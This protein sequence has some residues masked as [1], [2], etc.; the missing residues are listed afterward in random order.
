MKN[1]IIDFIKGF[2]LGLDS[3]I[4]GFSMGT[5]AIILKIY[6]RMIED[7]SDAP[8]HPIKFLKKD[9]FMIVGLLMGLVVNIIAI[10]YL[11][12][13]FPLQAVCF[14][15][16]L[17]LCGIPQTFNDVKSRGI[18]FKEVLCFIIAIGVLVFVTLLNAGENQEVA[19][20]PLSLIMM[21]VVGSIGSGTMIIP[22]VSGSMIMMAIGYYEPTIQVINNVIRLNDFW[23]NALLFGCFLVGVVL[24]LIL[25]SKIIKFAFKKAPSAVYSSILGL[26]VGSPFAM[27]YLTS[28][29]YEIDFTNVW[30]YITSAIMLLLGIVAG[31]LINKQE[32][33]KNEHKEETEEELIINESEC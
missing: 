19:L 32:K 14:F 2:L 26:L 12:R 17:V 9:F 22:G 27:I 16:G 29:K 20:S 6:D 18:K 25:V 28:K 1:K 7:F 5:L 3:T 24:G 30:I 33:K 23:S 31:I 13:T 8:K 21:V 10:S 15:V 4:P 11:L